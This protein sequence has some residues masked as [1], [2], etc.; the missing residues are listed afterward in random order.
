MFFEMRLGRFHS[1]VRCDFVVGA[2]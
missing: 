2:G 1:V